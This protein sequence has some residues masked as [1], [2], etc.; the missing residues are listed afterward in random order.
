MKK[1]VLCFT[2]L[3]CILTVNSQI[4]TSP[5]FI[6]KGYQGE[7]KIIFNP[8]EGN[9]GMSN[10]TQCY[11]H[12]GLITSKSISNNDWKYAPEWRGGENKYKMTKEGDNW[13]LYI[14]NIYSYYGCPET[15]EIIAMAFVFN[16]GP[17]GSK[18][19]KAK[20]GS[21]IFVYL[22]EPGLSIKFNN[23]K[24]PFVNKN[25]SIIFNITTSDTADIK[26]YINAILCSQTNGNELKYKYSFN[27]YGYY[28]CI[29]TATKDTTTVTDTMNIFC[30]SNTII[31]SRPTE[32]NDGITYYPEDNTKISLSLYTRNKK[33]QDA[34]H[35]YIIGDF[36]NWEYSS[37]YQMK[38]DTATGYHWLTI[39]NLTPGEKYRFQ[40]SIER[41]DNSFVQISEPYSEYI[42]EKYDTY[43]PDNIYSDKIEYP[44][45]GDGP[46]S[47]FSTTKTDFEW[48]DET[49]QFQA[50]DK[51][52]LLIYEVWVYDFSPAR[53]FQGL[54]DRLDYI[55]NLGVNAIELMPISEFDGNISWG[56]NPTHYFALDKSYGNK[57]DFKTLVDEAHKRGIAV[58]VDMVINHATDIC[59]LFKIHPIQDNPYFNTSAP[60]D[61]NVFNDFNH[62]FANTRKYFKDMLYYWLKEYKIDGFR[63]DLSH[64]LCGVDCNNRKNNV[65]DYYNNGVRRYDNDKYFILEHWAFNGERENYV[66]NGMMCW[67]NTS[68]AYCQTAMGWLTDDNFTNANK[69]GFVSY[70]E[71]HD[72]ERCF[73]KAK[74]WGKGNIATDEDVRLN[75]VA[76]NVAMS[77]MLNGPQ[78]IWQFEELGYDYSIEE[79]GRTGTK[80]M[81]ELLGYYTDSR[82]MSQYQK[83][84]YMCNLR[85]RLAPEI[86]SQDP[87]YHQ[88]TSGNKKRTILWGNDDEMIFVICNLSA[89]EYVPY[90]LPEENV[91]YQFLPY[92]NTPHKNTV[93]QKLL[94]GEVKIFTT[95]RYPNPNIPNSYSFDYVTQ[96]NETITKKCNV[97]PTVTSDI[98]YIET[99]EEIQSID[100]ISLSG[101]YNR[102]KTNDNSINISNLPS[103]IYIIVITT[104]SHQEHFKIIKK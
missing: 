96:T 83:I 33:G 36:N 28:K 89:D 93:S 57:D 25:D 63:M 39:C 73:Y 92:K 77:V 17:N 32:I 5:S 60:H 99:E 78:M 98:V 101:Q 66:Q 67:E 6:E 29:A 87:K 45:Q 97:Y 59:P 44:T 54:I 53:S 104:S 15:E 26:F 18:E 82:R 52:N 64:G 68:N 86:F 55:D 34:K 4:T 23:N 1:L 42:V 12:T 90:F 24:N 3:I 22:S 48:S 69:D 40:Y 27:N 74:T 71:S 88:L 21:D 65:Y 51:D 14:S 50:P 95:K 8:N 2:L 56:Y 11:A 70:A 91:W 49:L 84:G 9:K 76:A 35:V 37:E 10:A 20:D 47:V 46:V 94:P 103:G 72:E 85:T 16:D 7:I 62:D 80:P 43:I 19:G 102:I 58:I 38:L 31:E 75:R 79:N 81:P 13:V 30:A 61:G 100:L 41:Y